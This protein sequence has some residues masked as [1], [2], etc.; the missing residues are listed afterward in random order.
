MIKHGIPYM[1]QKI[2][3]DWGGKLVIASAVGT[4]KITRQPGIL[5]MVL[6]L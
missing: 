3:Y 2:F 6:Y 4:H 5:T 1:T